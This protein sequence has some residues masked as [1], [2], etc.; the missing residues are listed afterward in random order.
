MGKRVNFCARS[1]VTCDSYI[2]AD[3]IMDQA[4]FF[5][6]M[7]LATVPRNIA[8]RLTVPVV[9][10]TYNVRELTRRM[11]AGQVLFLQ[12]ASN[13]SGRMRS[14]THV[15]IQNYVYESGDAL[16]RR[17]MKFNPSNLPLA[18]PEDI[19]LPIQCPSGFT[20]LCYGDRIRRKRDGSLMDPLSTI[21]WPTLHVGDTVLVTPK[22]GDWCLTFVSHDRISNLVSVVS[23]LW[24]HSHNYVLPKKKINHSSGNFVLYRCSLRSKSATLRGM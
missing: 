13:G 2:K 4:A 19:P 22:D 6:C 9:I 10:H 11:N 14:I 3:E 8:S 7:R 21:A 23:S 15:A 1:V 24:S 20:L 18:C 5:F 16:I 12:R 17:G